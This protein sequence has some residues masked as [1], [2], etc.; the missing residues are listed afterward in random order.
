MLSN[1]AQK[2]DISL[3]SGHSI[4]EVQVDDRKGSKH[5]GAKEPETVT[6]LLEQ[7]SVTHLTS[8]FHQG[9]RFLRSL[10]Q[11]MKHGLIT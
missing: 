2:L 8:Y 3:G 10:L 4:F 1:K 6:K 11:K 7:D 5:P 9:G